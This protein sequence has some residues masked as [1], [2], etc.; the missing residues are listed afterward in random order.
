MPART[1]PDFA[2]QMGVKVSRKTVHG[3]SLCCTELEASVPTVVD[4]AVRYGWPVRMIEGKALLR[5][6]KMPAVMQ[7]HDV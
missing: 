2:I 7:L 6:R 4:R 5:L 3:A 1:Q